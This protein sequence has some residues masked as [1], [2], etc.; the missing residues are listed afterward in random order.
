MSSNGKD[1]QDYQE[2]AAFHRAALAEQQHWEKIQREKQR[3]IQN[4][5]MAQGYLNAVQQTGGLGKMLT[6]GYNIPQSQ[7]IS[8]PPRVTDI[9]LRSGDLASPLFDTPLPTLSAMWLARFGSGWVTERQIVAAAQEVTGEWGLLF[10]RLN[11]RNVFERHTLY[12]TGEN[13]FR[14][15]QE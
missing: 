9:Q 4:N 14:L 8:R 3:A 6:S 15:I 13:V 1:F 5:N 12:D 2:E 10:S 7:A 11:A